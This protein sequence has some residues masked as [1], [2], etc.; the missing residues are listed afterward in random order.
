MQAASCP[1]PGILSHHE[2]FDPESSLELLKEIHSA[3]FR[4]GRVEIRQNDG[5]NA[6]RLQRFDL[7][8]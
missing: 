6:L 2:A 5:L 1:H 3:Q 4:E 7:L 8:F